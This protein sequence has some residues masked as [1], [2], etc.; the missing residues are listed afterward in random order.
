MCALALKIAQLASVERHQTTA[1]VGIHRQSP[2]P[3][4]EQ[5]AW[6]KCHQENQMAQVL[7]WTDMLNTRHSMIVFG[8][9]AFGN[10]LR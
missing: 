8:D 7:L 5:D 9:N 2:V 10:L 6:K 1:D 4:N 3:G